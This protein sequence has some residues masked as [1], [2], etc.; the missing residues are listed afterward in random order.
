M[1]ELRELSSKIDGQIS[2]LRELATAK[3]W[4][5]YSRHSFVMNLSNV[6]PGL[7]ELKSLFQLSRNELEKNHAPQAQSVSE[8]VEELNQ[9]IVV[10]KRNKEMEQARIQKIKSQ[11]IHSVAETITVP[12]LYS[13]LEQKTL[14]ALLKSAYGAERIRLAERKRE[15]LMQARGPQKNL[16]DLLEIKEKE[17]EDLKRKYEE[18][19]NKTF[20]GLVERESAVEIENQLNLL[21]RN[22]EGKTATTKKLAEHTKEA[23][24]GMH[25]QLQELE[26]GVAGAEE[27]QS[28]MLGKTFELM[29]LLKKERDY[30]KKV[31]LEIQQETLE[32]RNTYS[33][34][35]F[36]LQEEKLSLKST[37]EDRHAKEMESL[38]HE[39][40]EKASLLKH[41]QETSFSKEKKV[42]DLEEENDKLRLVNKMLEKH[43]KVKEKFLKG[44]K[45]KKAVK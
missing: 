24:A 39:L 27:M 44:T 34:E 38:R 14:S 12:E 3:A 33:K 8:Q 20:L 29:T 10:L 23:L 31:L 17:I 45:K 13:D 15:P 7:Q 37:L 4:G 18:A 5:T 11:S 40:R 2:Q 30:A 1:A 36:G 41:F 19:R 28:Q 26:A 21:A 32:L 25:R 42:G 6:I 16:L 9:L 22:L 43:E 35:L